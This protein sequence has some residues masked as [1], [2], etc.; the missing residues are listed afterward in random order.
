MYI[1]ICIYMYVYTLESWIIGGVGII[2]G[3]GVGWGW[4][5]S[6]VGGCLGLMLNWTQPF[7]STNGHILPR[8]FNTRKLQKV[9]QSFLLHMLIL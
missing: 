8:Q 9:L 7:F 6:S 5:N 4:K 1:Y 2:G 3:G